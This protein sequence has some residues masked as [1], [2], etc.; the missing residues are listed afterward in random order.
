MD[1]GDSTLKQVDP[2]PGKGG[3][4]TW[5]RPRPDR[6]PPRANRHRGLIDEIWRAKFVANCEVF[7]S[8]IMH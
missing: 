5:G 3:A 6:P 2:L 7:R 1:P 4:G 8:M